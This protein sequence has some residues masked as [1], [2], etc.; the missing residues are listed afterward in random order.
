MGK[1]RQ[2][3]RTRLV[4]YNLLIIV[5]VIAIS[6]LFIAQYFFGILQQQITQD[7]S[8]TLEKS[9]LHVEYIQAE[10][11]QMAKIIAS[12]AQ[13]LSTIGKKSESAY[14]FYRRS[15]KLYSYLR[16]YKIMKN[17]IL[18]IDLLTRDGEAYSSAK[19]GVDA[20]QEYPENP[21][22]EEMQAREARSGFSQPHTMTVPPYSEREAITYFSTCSNYMTNEKDIALLMVHIDLSLFQD[23]LQMSHQD[24]D[25]LAIA[26]ENGKTILWTGESEP[27]EALLPAAGS[28]NEP[29]ILKKAS[30]TIFVNSGLEDGWRLVL[31]ISNDLIFGKITYLYQ[32]F[33]IFTIVMILIGIVTIIP[34]TMSLTRPIEQLTAMAR[35]VSGGNLKAKVSIE[36]NDEL[37]VLSEVFNEMLIS[38]QHQMAQIV[39]DQRINHELK[40]DLL[41]AQIN[42]HFIYNTLNSVIYLSSMGRSQE[43]CEI[44]RAFVRILQDNLKIGTEGVISSVREEL[45]IVRD[46]AEIQCYRYPDRFQLKIEADKD[47]LSEPVPR[48]LLQPL[49]ENSLYHGILPIEEKGNIV[50]RIRKTALSLEIEV[51]DDGIGMSREKTES[52]LVGENL[53]NKAQM[54]SIGFFNIRERLQLLYQDRFSLAV[55]SA[56]G[57]GT[58]VCIV[59]PLFRTSSL[60]KAH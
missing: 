10:I 15:E 6:V 31:S 21:W 26:S 8:A 20:E 2:K 56:P 29:Q 37:G 13:I 3:L 53:K 40:I 51:Q 39:E 59:L 27:T 48:I 46:Y 7:Y 28:L 23:I 42:P 47:S 19:E 11:Q 54:R 32:F 1:K 38:L 41:M 43:V 16:Q 18:R 50:I 60:M 24:Y 58:K 25:W 49:V 34:L 17:Y 35:Q 36:G 55:D 14:E 5:C 22:F 57:E 12:D 4:L 44:S 52:L 33:I 45:R 30:Q 9:A